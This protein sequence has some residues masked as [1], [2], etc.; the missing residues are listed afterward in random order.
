[1]RFWGATG[2]LA[3]LE[4]AK[5]ALPALQGLVDEKASATA[6][7]AAEALAQ[8]G[9]KETANK[10]YVRIMTDPSYELPD[11]NFALNSIDAIDF[12]TPE[13][14]AAIKTCYEKN[15]EYMEGFARY[16]HYDA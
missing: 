6:V 9:D 5:P 15:K 1:I 4:N 2:M 14:E 10:I 12:K 7:L 13:I 16:N 8:L 11:R 3:H